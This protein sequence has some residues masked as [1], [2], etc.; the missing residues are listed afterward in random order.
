MNAPEKAPERPE[1]HRVT[2]WLT[3]AHV[4]ASSAQSAAEHGVCPDLLSSVFLPR[5][6]AWRC[7]P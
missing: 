6:P 1:E 3:A 2:A 5:F 4:V 7:V